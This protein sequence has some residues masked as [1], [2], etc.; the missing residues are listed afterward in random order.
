MKIKTIL[1]INASIILF[2]MVACNQKSES[3]NP[4]T[5]INSVANTNLNVLFEKYWDQR[6]KL[7]PVDATF[8]G[9]NRYNDQLPNDQTQAY[10][11]ALALTKGGWKEMRA[12]VRKAG[13]ER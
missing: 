1:S 13:S 2:S 7:F 3:K 4:V 10:R 9:D 5:T 12:F 11:D 8:F 6:M